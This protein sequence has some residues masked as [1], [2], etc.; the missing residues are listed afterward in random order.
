MSAASGASGGPLK[1]QVESTGR[2][3]N[4]CRLSQSERVLFTL[5]TA[6]IRSGRTTEDWFRR[7]EEQ[8]D[9][10]RLLS[11]FTYQVAI[12]LANGFSLCI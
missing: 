11:L 2:N 3:R 7:Y 12:D 10:C 9:V 1:L 8:T 6:P 4:Q 5:A